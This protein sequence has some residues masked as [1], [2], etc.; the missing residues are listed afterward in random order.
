M[1]ARLLAPFSVAVA[2]VACDEL[3][4]DPGGGGGTQPPND[5]ISAQK[6]TGGILCGLNGWDRDGDTISFN[7]EINAVNDVGNGGFYT[8]NN[9]RWDVNES[10]ARGF[11]TNGSLYKGMNLLDLSTGYTHYDNCERFVFPA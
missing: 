10:Q 1:A 8:F 7:T 11:A 2:L 4:Y 9:L 5:C 6:P 3:R